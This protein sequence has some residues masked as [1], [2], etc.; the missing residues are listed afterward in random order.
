MPLEVPAEIVILLRFA[1]GVFEEQASRIVGRKALLRQ[2]R[3]L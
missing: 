1:H 2:I 3:P